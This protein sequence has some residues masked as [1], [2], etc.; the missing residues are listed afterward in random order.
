MK[1]TNDVIE[2][3]TFPLDEEDWC[4]IWNC[5][6]EDNGAKC[7]IPVDGDGMTEDMQRRLNKKDWIE[8]YCALED[9]RDALKLGFYGRDKL[10]RE[11]R[12]HV[13]AMMDT[14][15]IVRTFIG[16]MGDTV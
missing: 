15:D 6:T 10:A 5:L 12:Q 11:W 16:G 8:I 2:I 13:E 14:L 7:K 9:K 1:P 3:P 4:E